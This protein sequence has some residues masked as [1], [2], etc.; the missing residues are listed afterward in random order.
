MFLKQ[1]VEK[2][3]FAPIQ[4]QW[5]HSIDSRISPKLKEGPETT[6][7]LQELYKE[8]TDDFHNVIVKHT[9]IC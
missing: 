1:C 2:R 6:K 8:V 7:L 4:Q 9:G 5:L 3:S